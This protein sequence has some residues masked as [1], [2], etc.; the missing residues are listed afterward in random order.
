MARK[1]PLLPLRRSPS[2]DV[3]IDAKR[4]LWCHGLAP[5][6][7][8]DDPVELLRELVAEYESQLPENVRNFVQARVNGVTTWRAAAGL[9]QPV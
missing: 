7:V 2:T 4:Y 6:V 8:V 1:K 9:K 3:L 5:D